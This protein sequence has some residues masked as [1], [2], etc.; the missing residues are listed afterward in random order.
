[1]AIRGLSIG[2][3]IAMIDS[4]YCKMARVGTIFMMT[5]LAVP[6]RPIR[7]N[8]KNTNRFMMPAIVPG[9]SFTTALALRLIL[10]HKLLGSYMISNTWE[11]V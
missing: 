6:Y 7:P 5:L 1:M 9:I 8:K 11:G 2:K 4:K 3:N 10:S